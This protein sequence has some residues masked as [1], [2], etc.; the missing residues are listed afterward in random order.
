MVE[1]QRPHSFL[2]IVDL[3]PRHRPCHLFMIRTDKSSLGEGSH[4][5]APIETLQNFF[6]TKTSTFRQ[7]LQLVARLL[8]LLPNF[9]LVSIY[10]KLKVSVNFDNG[11][12]D[13]F[14]FANNIETVRHLS[15]IVQ[16]VPLWHFDLLRRTVE[17]NERNSVHLLKE[18]KFG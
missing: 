8:R 10:G 6:V 3:F 18:V 5:T 2:Q 1:I 11:F 13:E 17:I 16:C 15:N 9:P 4:P 14:S 12:H 7:I